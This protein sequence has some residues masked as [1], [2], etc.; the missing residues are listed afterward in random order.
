MPKPH[1][2]FT[3]NKGPGRPLKFTPGEI[4]LDIT[5]GMKVTVVDYRTDRAGRGEYRVIRIF[6]PNFRVGKAIWRMSWELEKVEP[7]VL[8]Y[9]GV[10]VYRA[11]QRLGPAKER[12]CSCQCCPHFSLPRDQISTDGTWKDVDVQ[13][14]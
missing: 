7:R 13:E 11:N 4:A 8:S 12:G 10:L 3:G 2:S 5:S 6:P 14:M 1:K 9:I